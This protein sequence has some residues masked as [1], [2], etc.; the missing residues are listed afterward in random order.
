LKKKGDAGHQLK[1]FHYVDC[2]CSATTI[3]AVLTLLTDLKN[4]LGFLEIHLEKPPI[5]FDHIYPRKFL[6]YT[7]FE[8]SKA[9]SVDRSSLTQLICNGSIDVM[10]DRKYYKRSAMN[11]MNGGEHYISA[12][13]KTM[14]LQMNMNCAF[15]M[16]C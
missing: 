6:I 10:F 9:I 14:A 2:D 8:L 3:T 16:I 1:Q 13:F 7:H 11:L 15:K 12:P 5:H 4:V